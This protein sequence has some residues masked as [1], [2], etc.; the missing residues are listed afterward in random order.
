MVMQTNLALTTTG[1]S[2]GGYAAR[3]AKFGYNLRRVR[4]KS[5]RRVTHP[6]G[7]YI[8]LQFKRARYVNFKTN[9]TYFHLNRDT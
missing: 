1:L 4:G 5:A 7:G 8:L 2:P 3:L 6:L 9:Q